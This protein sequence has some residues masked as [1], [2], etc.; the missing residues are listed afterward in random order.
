MSLPID[1]HA[2]LQVQIAQR[3]R[4]FC[5]LVIH[6]DKAVW[7]EPIVGYQTRVSI[8]ENQQRWPGSPPP[9]L[10]RLVGIVEVGVLRRGPVRGKQ[11]LGVLRRHACT[12]IFESWKGMACQA[13]ALFRSHLGAKIRRRMW[14][15]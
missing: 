14:C 15:R 3:Q 12:A 11:R 10:W 6:E 5:S 9:P 7:L 4:L 8:F 1:L 13:R 2:A